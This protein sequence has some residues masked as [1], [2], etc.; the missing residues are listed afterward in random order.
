MIELQIELYPEHLVN[1][2]LSTIAGLGQLDQVLDDDLKSGLEEIVAYA[3]V[4]APVD[5][6]RLRDSIRHE[7]GNR[8]YTI[9][10]D[11]KNPDTGRGYARYV[12]TGCFFSK[13][14]KI[15]TKDGWKS[16]KNLKVGDLVFTHKKRFKPVVA[17][18]HYKV[19]KSPVKITVDIGKNKLTVTDNHPFF[20]I[21]NNKRFWV[22]AKNVKIGDK[23]I[24]VFNDRTCKICGKS[25]KPSQ[26]VVCSMECNWKLPRRKFKDL[27][28]EQQ[29]EIKQK[30]SKI[31]TEWWKNKTPEERKQITSHGLK[32]LL[33]FT[34]KRKDLS[35]E[36]IKEWNKKI[37]EGK[38]KWWASKTPEERSA[39][40]KKS[41]ANRRSYKGK[42][43]PHYGKHNKR[44]ISPETRLKLSLRMRGRNNIMYKYPRYGHYYSNYGFRE[45]LGHICRSSWE[46]NIC[47]I[48]NSLNI[49]YEFEP[50]TFNLSDGSS[51]TPD[52]LVYDGTDKYFVEIK[53]HFDK[54]FIEKF[55]KFVKEYPD[56]KIQLI[57]EKIYKDIEKVWC[58]KI[59]KWE[60]TNFKIFDPDNLHEQI[61][62][63]V[64]I[65]KSKGGNILNLY[66]L[67][68][69]DDHSYIANNFIVHNT[70]LMPAQPYMRPA[71]D[72]V[73]PKL[74]EMLK[75]DL[76]RIVTGR[77]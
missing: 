50:K 61:C 74:V 57:N 69:K 58:E 64:N 46:A 5:T 16:W 14:T 23:V 67:I 31:K 39:I 38:K 35:S 54:G 71:L 66:D 10:A 36:K 30:L 53:G 77:W 3:Q 48:L 56:V 1:Y 24:C 11:P 8:E 75:G 27:P 33:E 32:Y 42:N 76:E 18:V 20:V 34:Y 65:K 13:E 22:K 45:D 26:K 7:G 41:A 59:P 6:G 2:I 44:K 40:A 49:G 43:N 37:S 12:E 21:R 17:K 4:Y 62:E 15:L 68:V 9:I 72:Q 60:G 52:L 51:Y 70:S 73:M 25:L 19:E 47:R 55:K 29:M 63:V 28:L